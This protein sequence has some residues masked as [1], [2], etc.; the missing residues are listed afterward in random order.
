MSNV[1]VDVDYD[2][3]IYIIQDDEGIHPTD[4]IF[5]HTPPLNH[6]KLLAIHFLLNQ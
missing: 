1:L 2:F 4:L 6:S 3:P 5:H